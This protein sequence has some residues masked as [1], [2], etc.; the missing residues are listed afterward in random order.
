MKHTLEIRRKAHYFIQKPDGEIRSVLYVIHGYGQLAEDFIEEFSFL[1]KTNTLV[2]AP[3]AISKFYNKERKAVANWMT[4][5]ERLD[6][7]DDY[8][9][10]LN[11]LENTVIDQYG[12]LPAGVLGFSQ[13]VSTALR[14]VAANQV[15]YNC[16]YA[17]SGSIPPELKSTSFEDALEKG[18]Y[19]YYGDK[20][21]LLS[22]EN[23]KK[24]FGLL[25]DLGLKVHP[26]SFHGVHEISQETRDDLVKF[27]QSY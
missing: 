22:I 12:I 2:V 13:G 8:I 27:S 23:A 17:C 10:Y 14:W 24:Q 20:D 25:C 11:Q 16:F 7:I 21:R 6:E 18:F 4:S 5:H 19:Y 1:K 3:E 9:S 26:M 15:R